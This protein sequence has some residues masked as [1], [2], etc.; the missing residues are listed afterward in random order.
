M[1]RRVGRVVLNRA[2]GPRIFKLDFL[3]NE[4]RREKIPFQIFDSFLDEELNCSTRRAAIAKYFV[5]FAEIARHF[6]D[7]GIFE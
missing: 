1:V 2:R 6:D 5:R 4:T 3:E 7:I